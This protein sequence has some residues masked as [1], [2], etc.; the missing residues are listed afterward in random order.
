MG[1][2]SRSRPRNRSPDETVLLDL[3][4]M[5]ESPYK[6]ALRFQ[7]LL[8]AQ[9]KKLYSPAAQIVYPRIC[10]LL[11][12]IVDQLEEASAPLHIYRWIVF[13]RTLPDRIVRLALALHFRR[14]V[15]PKKPGPS[16]TDQNWLKDAK[17]SVA[18]KLFYET[19]PGATLRDWIR[20]NLFQMRGDKGSMDADF[21]REVNQRVRSIDR[22]VFLETVEQRVLFKPKRKVRFYN[23]ERRRVVARMSPRLRKK[24]TEI[25]AELVT[26]DT[27]GET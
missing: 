10:A 5:E 27:N 18:E 4:P 12:D 8:P 9:K 26:E 3:L 15:N 14:S 1:S 19:T 23:G 20:K 16:A 11:P 17:Q 6:K 24:I 22:L 21:W 13:G 7:K 2:F 25:L